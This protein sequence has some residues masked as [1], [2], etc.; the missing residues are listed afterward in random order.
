SFRVQLMP[1]ARQPRDISAGMRQAC[2]EPGLRWVKGGGDHDDRSGV[3]RLLRRLSRG[4]ALCHDH[5]DVE[6]QQCRDSVGEFR[7]ASEG[8]TV[9]DEDVLALDIAA[10]AQSVAKRG[11]AWRGRAGP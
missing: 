6:S 8:R 11:K 2:D 1:D 4:T 10:F 5:I 3:R 9:L 7:V